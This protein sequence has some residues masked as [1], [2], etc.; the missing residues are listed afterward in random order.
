MLSLCINN[1]IGHAAAY[2]LFLYGD[3]LFPE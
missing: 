1:E 3:L 2:G